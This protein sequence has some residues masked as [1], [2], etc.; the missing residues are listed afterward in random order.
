MSEGLLT[1]RYF[2]TKFGTAAGAKK[3][4]PLRRCGPRRC[5]GAGK[6][7]RVHCLGAGFAGGKG[8][9]QRTILPFL[10]IIV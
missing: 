2:G 9:D 5:R 3:A 1:R 6:L 7:G 4:T 10:N 8:E